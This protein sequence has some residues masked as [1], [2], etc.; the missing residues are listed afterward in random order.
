MVLTPVRLPEIKLDLFAIRLFIK[1]LTFF[2]LVPLSFST[3]S[4]KGSFNLLPERRAK[5]RSDPNLDHRSVSRT[6]SGHRHYKPCTKANSVSHE[7]PHECSTFPS[8]NEAL[9]LVDKGEFMAATTNSS[10]EC[11]LLAKDL[12]Q[13]DGHYTA[14]NYF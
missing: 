9:L 4:S 11:S 12:L 5:I 3:R 6:G 7:E 13:L 14:N 1:K 10:W 2:A 8:A